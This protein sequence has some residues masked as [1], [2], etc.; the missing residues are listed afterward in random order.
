[1]VFWCAGGKGAGGGGK[2]AELVFCQPLV[3]NRTSFIL[4]KAVPLILHK[5]GHRS[6][7]QSL[8]LQCCFSE[9]GLASHVVLCHHQTEAIAKS[10]SARQKPDIFN[11]LES[12]IF[13]SL[14]IWPSILSTISLAAHIV[15]GSSSHRSVSSID[16]QARIRSCVLDVCR[17][18]WMF[19]YVSVCA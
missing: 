7:L 19:A 12:C 14:Q 9:C 4:Y 8:V 5:A 13:N 11:S 6:C 3:R 2:N 16:S 1:M 15:F 10:E 18:C 17:D